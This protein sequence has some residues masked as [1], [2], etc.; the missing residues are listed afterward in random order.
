MARHRTG[1]GC[2][3]SMRRN[4]IN[5]ALAKL[6]GASSAVFQAK[7]ASIRVD[8]AGAAQGVVLATGALVLHGWRA[9]VDGIA[10]AL[11]VGGQAAQSLVGD[12]HLVEH[13]T[14]AGGGVVVAGDSGDLAAQGVGSEQAADEA[15]DVVC[16]G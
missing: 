9:A 11:A 8:D 1:Q 12:D 3:I 16:D 4:F 6:T 15:V 5:T 14:L 13:G 7:L 2:P 10:V